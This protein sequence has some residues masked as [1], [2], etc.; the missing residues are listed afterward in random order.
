MIVFSFNIF[1]EY[2]SFENT[3]HYVK[4]AE[5]KWSQVSGYMAVQEDAIE[6][7][8]DG[9]KQRWKWVNLYFIQNAISKLWGMYCCMWDKQ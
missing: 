7:M 1:Q 8:S 3:E 9:A 4:H 2:E 6:G 5:E